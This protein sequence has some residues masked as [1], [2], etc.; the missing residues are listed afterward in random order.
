MRSYVTQPEKE[1]GVLDPHMIRMKFMDILGNSVTIEN[2]VE[3]TH[4]KPWKLT[5]EEVSE[6]SKIA[7]TIAHKRGELISKSIIIEDTIEESIRNIL[8]GSKRTEPS[9]LFEEHILRTIFFS[10]ENKRIVLQ[11]LLK[12]LDWYDE[13]YKEKFK[14]IRKANNFRNQFAH[15]KI[16]FRGKIAFL[17][18]VGDNGKLKEKE[19]SKDY[20]TDIYETLKSAN[21]RSNEISGDISEFLKKG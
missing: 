6:M 7:E 14:E 9:K 16:I 20:F 8:F 18:Y 10:F 17:A 21:L 4:E 2:P 19:L 13:K 12:S 5:E 3:I 15:G 11:R 1:G